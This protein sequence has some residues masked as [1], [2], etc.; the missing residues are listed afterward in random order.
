MKHPDGSKCLEGIPQAPKRGWIACCERFARAT[1]ACQYEVRIE[2]HGKHRW[3]MPVLDGGSS[4]I[5]IKYCPFCGA[6]L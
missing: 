6:M 5:K 1:S 4:F 3:G 2:W